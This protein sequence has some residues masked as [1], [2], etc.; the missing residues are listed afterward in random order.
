MG[1]FIEVNQVDTISTASGQVLTVTYRVPVKDGQ[2][3]LSLRDLGGSD[4]NVVLNGLQVTSV[5]P[6]GPRVIAA[7]PASTILGPV[8]HITLTFDEAIQDGTF[9]LV[10]IAGLT[11]S[12]ER[13]VGKEVRSRVWV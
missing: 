6:A 13:R 8:D 3:T 4:V 1:V 12:E 2:L 7:V 5:G 10:D 11:R 9:T